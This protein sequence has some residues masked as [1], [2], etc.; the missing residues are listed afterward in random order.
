MIGIATQDGEPQRI[1][2]ACSADDRYAAPLTV[3][4]KSLEQ[5]LAP[6]V[7]V[8][9]FVLGIGIRKA[10]RQKV[11]ASLD[12]KR[13]HLQ[14]LRVPGTVRAFPVFGHVSPATY[15]RLLIPDLLPS[16]ITKTIYLDSD[17]VVLGDVGELW[18]LDMAGAPLLAAQ[19]EGLVLGSAGG[20]AVRELGLPPE[21]KYLNAGVMVMDLTQWRREEIHRRVMAY[22]RQYR[23]R[24]Q[25]WDQD[26]INAILATRWREI[27]REWNVRVCPQL[28]ESGR[29]FEEACEDLRL[30]AK[31]IHYASSVKPWDREAIHPGKVF[32]HD[33]LALTAW[34]DW[35]PKSSPCRRRRWTRHDYGRRLRQMPLIGWWWSKLRPAGK[36][37]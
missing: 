23:D 17:I 5:H 4:L 25:F 12:A 37:S 31:L 33:V 21:A 2:L 22:L 16:A 3:M 29:T 13:M 6:G 7:E 34:R 28:T 9:V 35:R 10:S 27:G 11:V 14:W 32:F 18:G 24:V 20:V 36:T 1:V 19:D 30:R 8:D 15:S 26:G